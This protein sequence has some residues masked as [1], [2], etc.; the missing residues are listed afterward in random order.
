SEPTTQSASARSPCS[1]SLTCF[2]SLQTATPP[3]ADP[4]QTSWCSGSATATLK[5]RLSRSFRLRNTCL[6]SFSDCASGM[7]SSRVSKPTGICGSG[8]KPCGLFFAGGG[9]GLS[10][11]FRG[12]H[13]GDAEAFQDVANLDI[14]EV[15]HTRAAFEARA[16]FAGVVLK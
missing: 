15:G 8:E 5:S 14:V 1:T 12:A 4:S 16:H 6:L 2:S 3:T 9:A 11:G 10:G 13:L 7:C